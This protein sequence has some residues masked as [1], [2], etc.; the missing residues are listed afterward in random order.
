MLVQNMVWR[1]TKECSKGT[2]SSNTTRLEDKV[3]KNQVS[4]SQI[5][6]NIP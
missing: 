4:H 2:K 6:G 3:R 5:V 1:N